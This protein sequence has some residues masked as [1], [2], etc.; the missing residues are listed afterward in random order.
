MIVG[1]KT[2]EYLGWERVVSHLEELA[3]TEPGRVKVRALA[4]L[5]T[6][7]AVE[8]ELMAVEEIKALL[9]EEVWPDLGG[10][11]DISDVVGRAAREGVLTPVE[12]LAVADCTGGLTRVR[13]FITGKRDRLEH[14]VWLLVKL[15]DVGHVAS[16]V[17]SSLERDG[18]V[19]DGASATLRELREAASGMHQ[20]IR[21]RVDDYLRSRPAEE[22][23]QEKY[24]TLREDRYVLP[25]RAE[26]Q[27]VV[28]GII[29]GV[30]QTGATVFLEPDFLISLNNRL[31]LVEEE[32]HIEEYRVLK[33]LTDEVARSSR[34]ILES[35]EMAALFDSYLARARMALGMDAGRPEVGDDTV[36]R[37]K[38]A[39][40]P[41][42]LIQGRPV[43]PNDVEVGKGFRLLVLSGP[44][45]G[46]KSVALKTC[47]LCV[48]MAHTGML[49]PASPDSYLPFLDGLHALPGDLE[50]VEEQLSTFTGHL[51]ELNRT[52][53]SVGPGH[54]V[55]IDEIAIG[56]EPEQGSALG[57]GYLLELA[58]T[59]AL[60]LVATHYERLKALAMADSRFCNASMGMDWEHLQPTYRMSIGIPG[61]SRTLEIARR[62]DVPKRVLDRAID[63]LEGKSAA[64][65]EDAIRRLGEREKELSEAVARQEQ[66]TQEADK[67]KRRRELA[68]E[69]I[70]NH[71]ARII[72]TKVA[73]GLKEVEEALGKVAEVVARLQS[74]P[75]REE[76]PKLRSAL[77]AVKEEL[78]EKG[79]RLKDE[80]ELAPFVKDVRGKIEV[81]S[82]VLIRKFRRKAEVV[83]VSEQEGLATLKM[84]SMWMR[85]PLSELIPTDGENRD[86]GQIANRKSQITNREVPHAE[87]SAGRRVDIRGMT[88]DEGIS[89]LESTLDRAMLSP[90]GPIV[91]VHG[92][93]TGK[94]KAAVRDYLAKTTYP[95][96]FRPGKRDEG[97][98]GVT[99]VVTG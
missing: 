34:E 60:G 73:L 84:G 63:A 58:D 45:A 70:A 59:G 79:R 78:E 44:N 11:S 93:G 30:S 27:S 39:R 43:V 65:L 92:H 47:G 87:D 66:A 23:L 50:D 75:P 38:D 41:T 91:V 29:H 64:L 67:V 49:V 19:R 31:K 56:T 51:Q 72:S 6:R 13:S 28:D 52:M 95:V 14:L 77:E 98:D 61:S 5:K 32:I 89:L 33:D 17:A 24:Y 40:F 18:R 57:V 25:V 80:K 35:L 48:L 21:A 86:R 82:V 26:R 2:L 90:G 54:L 36:L 9:S 12:L 96:T 3:A 69:Q 76:L 68:L 20:T 81:G 99:V 4:F 1:D 71:A 10:I 46:G 37:L 55:L 22:V 15:H 97:G 88:V 83:S 42:M 62:F 94:L 53:R 7:E 16:D 85:L 8:S 74:L